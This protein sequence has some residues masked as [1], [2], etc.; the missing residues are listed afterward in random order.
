MYYKCVLLFAVPSVPL[1]VRALAITNTSVTLQ[2]HRPDRPNG[3]I[4][5]YRIY[6][7]RNNNFTDVVTIRRT[8]PI[9]THVIQDLGKLAKM[10]YLTVLLIQGKGQNCEPCHIRK[11]Y[12]ELH[13]SI[14]ILE[15]RFGHF[16]F[17]T[18]ITTQAAYCT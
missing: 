6:F 15:D 5:G 17:T 12:L 14:D 16:G 1:K 9:M 3:I 11:S 2:W 8:E 18:T 13:I 10:S 4:L 7:M